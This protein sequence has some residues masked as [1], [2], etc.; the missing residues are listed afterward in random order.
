[1]SFKRGF[2]EADQE[3]L[4]NSSHGN[5]RSDLRC[6]LSVFA[7]RAAGRRVHCA[8]CARAAAVSRVH[9]DANALKSPYFRCVWPA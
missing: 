9:G 3:A 2:D 7:D 6:R 1:M 8:V 4:A 5:A